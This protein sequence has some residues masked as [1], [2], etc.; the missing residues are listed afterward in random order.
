M[1]PVKLRMS[2]FGP[3]AGNIEL[4]M[5]RLGT[6][7]LY[8]I[9]GDTGAGKT[10][11]FDAVT[12]ALYGET[13]GGIRDAEMLRSKYA[14][15]ETRTE[16]ELT[17]EYG[18]REYTVRRNPKYE[19]PKLRGIGGMTRQNADAAYITRCFYALNMQGGLC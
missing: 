11:I 8:L 12:F 15:P 9:T 2:A 10:T 1:R 4:D 7:G 16:I 13:S 3:Y 18:G 17:F 19:R 5:N 14:E 6:E